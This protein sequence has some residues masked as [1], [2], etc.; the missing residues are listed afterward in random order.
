MRPRKRSVPIAT[1]PAPPLDPALA[2]LGAPDDRDAIVAACTELHLD[3]VAVAGGDADD[4]DALALALEAVAEGPASCLVVRRLGDLSDGDGGLA[5]VLD[6]I[7]AG[8]VRLVALDVGLDTA[9]PAGRMALRRRPRREA[10][11]L[12]VP[13]EPGDD[14]PPT[15]ETAPTAEAATGEA[16]APTPAPPAGTAEPVAEAPL[17]APTEQ[18]VAPPPAAAPTEQAVAPLPA[19]APPPGFAAPLPAAAPPP[20]FAAPAQTFAAPPHPSFAAPAPP[21]APA[22]PVAPT[23]PLAAIGYASAAGSKD[24]AA[25]AMCAQREAIA[26]HCD[27]CPDLTL[28]ELVGDRESTKDRKALDRPGLSHTLQRIAA[29]EVTCLVICGLD[30]LSRSVAELGQLLRWLDKM[31]VR[32][33]ALDLDLDTATESGRTTTRA[34]AAVSAWERERLS[35]RT[36]A[37]LAAAR[38]KR[39]AGTGAA[40]QR[41][42]AVHQRIAAMRA[43]GMTLQAIADVLNAEGVPTQRGG[44]KWRPSSVQSAAGYKRPQHARSASR[45]PDATPAP[46]PS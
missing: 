27:G 5:T 40:A 9:A 39:H 45:L 10:P 25:A 20:T 1:T 15:A 23:K 24:G 38:A 44:A 12:K 7:D 29:G 35:E 2:Y 6:R 34:L 17:T 26:R 36:K 3:V 33:V 19:A 46:T 14:A 30:H 11:W 43:D 4:H 42:A 18:A 16:V 28:L 8:G 41:T 22:G 31:D 32:L 13:E 37:G 21:A